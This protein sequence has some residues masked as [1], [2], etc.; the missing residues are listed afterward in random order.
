MKEIAFSADARQLVSLGAGELKVWDV[1]SGRQ[2]RETPLLL[3]R[4]RQTTSFDSIALALTPDGRLAAMAGGLDYRTGVLGFGGG[5]RAKPIRV[6]DAT[7]GRDVD[8]FKLAGDMPMPTG[9][10]FSPDGRMLA[11]K[12][13][14]SRARSTASVLTVYDVET[15]RPLKTFQSSDETASGGIEFSPDSKLL[16]SR[17]GVSAAPDTNDVNALAGLTSGSIELFDVTTWQRVRELTKTGSDLI[18]GGSNP[19]AMTP[20]IFSGDGKSLL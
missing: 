20:L 2:L 13:L 10:R 14:D 6:I 8:A 15:G 16:A 11:V 12:V 9:L 5:L 18:G 7:T 3:D 1:T 19:L 17:A 4:D